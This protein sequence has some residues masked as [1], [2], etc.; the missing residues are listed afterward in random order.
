MIPRR[1][2]LR[3]LLGLLGLPAVARARHEP[4]PEAFDVSVPLEPL[5]P[6]EPAACRPW[7]MAEALDYLQFNDPL[8]DPSDRTVARAL[9]RTGPLTWFHPDA[10]PG[11]VLA[12]ASDGMSDELIFW[13]LPPRTEGWP[14]G[15]ASRARFVAR[16]GEPRLAESVAWPDVGPLPVGCIR[17]GTGT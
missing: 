1:P 5:F 13:A 14:S 15:P 16:W 10:P 4:A 6:V 7:T 11:T 9:A 3:S 2:F 17:A 12:L 8:R